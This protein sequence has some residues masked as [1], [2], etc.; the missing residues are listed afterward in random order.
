MQNINQ[1][2][3]MLTTKNYLIDGHQDNESLDYSQLRTMTST[4]THDHN[5]L[6]NFNGS[7]NSTQKLRVDKQD[8]NKRE[9]HN[10]YLN[11]LA[12]TDNYFNDDS[13]E[14]Q[15]K[16]YQEDLSLQKND[17]NFFFD[18]TN[19]NKYQQ[20]HENLFLSEEEN[21]NIQNNDQFQMQQNTFLND[22]E[23][24]FVN[25]DENLF[26]EDQENLKIQLNGQFQIQQNNNPAKQLEY[27]P[28]YPQY[29]NQQLNYLNYP[30]NAEND[31]EQQECLFNQ[32]SSED[33]NELQI[34][35][36]MDFNYQNEQNIE[37]PPKCAAPIEKQIKKKRN[38]IKKQNQL[39][40]DKC[41]E[42]KNLANIIFR[43]LFQRVEEFGYKIEYSGKGSIGF[44]KFNNIL[45]EELNKLSNDDQQNLINVFIQIVNTS[46]IKK[47]INSK[48]YKTMYEII[49]YKEG[50]QVMI[51]NPGKFN[52]IKRANDYAIKQYQK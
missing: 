41:Q 19:Y 31:F 4:Q 34:Y 13:F 5:N 28:F 38:R 24:L 33:Q 44:T 9:I 1:T 10:E 30:I 2:E 18:N 52:S 20:T 15:I 22:E 35:Q 48:N 25:N 26:Q 45:I 11:L 32:E 17:I 6:N 3:I 39:G 36:R 12:V 8:E 47:A 43:F 49:K 7:E 50:L 37:T 42:T 51:Q 29:A 23:K 21:L 27:N 16:A 14:E 40:G 46:L